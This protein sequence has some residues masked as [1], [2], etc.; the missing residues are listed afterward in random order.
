VAGEGGVRSRR[1]AAK[2]CARWRALDDSTLRS[3]R[4]RKQPPGPRESG[5]NDPVKAGSAGRRAK[6]PAGGGRRAA[7]AARWNE[8]VVEERA[9]VGGRRLGC[10]EAVVLDGTAAEAEPGGCQRGIGRKADIAGR[11]R[12]RASE[13]TLHARRAAD[14][15]AVGKHGARGLRSR[16]SPETRGARIGERSEL[17]LRE[18]VRG[19]AGALKLEVRR[20]AK[21]HPMVRRAVARAGRKL[22]AR[23]KPRWVTSGGS[24]QAR[25]SRS[26]KATWLEE[27]RG[28]ESSSKRSARI[29]R[30]LQKSVRRIFLAVRHG[31]E[32]SAARAAARWLE[33]T[34]QPLTG[35][36]RARGE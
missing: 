26:R 25:R 27:T 1:A 31:A 23:R 34:H 9:L 6:A 17:R 5:G 21:L 4:K 20:Q 22:R 33:A 11:S 3:R 7:Q 8:T 15:A 24:A 18:I 14:K 30:R 13:A 16:S 29:E 36:G 10:G 32:Q 28:R 19:V 35:R 12:Q 2:P